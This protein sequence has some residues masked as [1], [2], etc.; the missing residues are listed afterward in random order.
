[1]SDERNS[2]QEKN[3]TDVTSVTQ[4]EQNTD[5]EGWAE[6]IEVGRR[7]LSVEQWARF[8]NCSDCAHQKCPTCTIEAI[9]CADLCHFIPGDV[10]E[11]LRGYPKLWDKIIKCCSCLSRQHIIDWLGLRF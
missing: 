9:D 1:M 10:Q 3:T 8:G 7:C 2:K 11:I 5:S 6:E 4:E